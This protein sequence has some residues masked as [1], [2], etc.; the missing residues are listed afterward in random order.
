MPGKTPI[1]FLS[2]ICFS[3][4]NKA[5]AQKDTAVVTATGIVLSGKMVK[6]NKDTTKKYNPNKAV[7]RSAII[8][9][10]GQIT[11]KKYWKLPLVYG[12]LGVTTGVFFHNVKQYK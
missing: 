2:L 1:I 10:W 3:F 9:G 4:C 8:P 12:A 7:I 6:A 5:L 11:N